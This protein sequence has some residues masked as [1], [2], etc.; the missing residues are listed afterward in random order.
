MQPRQPADAWPGA[1]GEDA[2]VARRLTH[3]LYRFDCPS[4]QTLGEYQLDLLAPEARTEVAAHL[5]G[6]PRCADELQTLRSFMSGPLV[7]GRTAAE[8]R[9]GALERL[10]RVLATLASPAAQPAFGGLRGTA[11]EEGQTYRAEELA[12]TLGPGPRGAR[13]R[14]SLL[15]L[16][17]AESAEAPALEGGEA[18]LVGESG[19]YAA[20]IDELGNFGLED[21][22][23]GTYRLELRLADRT[24]VIEDLRVG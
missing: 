10:R 6:C 1:S 12:V 21:V 16:V 20:P 15:G 14:V 4:P 18:Q 22:A 13:G 3:S 24:V 11:A 19:T 17:W 23:P 9:P 5:L 8:A 2:A 7:A